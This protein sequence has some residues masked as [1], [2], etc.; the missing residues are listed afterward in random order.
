MPQENMKMFVRQVDPKVSIIDIQGDLSA[1]AENALMDA[2][3]Q[4]STKTTHVIILNCT[5][6]AYMNSS[7]I[8]LLVT[9]LVRMNRQKQ[10]LFCY[11]LSEHYQHIFTLT[12]LNDVI[13]VYNSES[14]AVA[15]AALA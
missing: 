13:K 10:H 3:S 15:A 1:A 12:R 4:A 5:G 2:Y 14:E 7:G 9:L 6:L 8:G 11:G